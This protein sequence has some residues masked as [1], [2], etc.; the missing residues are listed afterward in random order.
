MAESPDPD[1]NDADF[2]ELDDDEDGGSF[3]DEDNTFS[4]NNFEDNRSVFATPRT[5]PVNSSNP[6][7]TAAQDVQRFQ[8]A[9]PAEKRFL[10]CQITSRGKPVV[11]QFLGKKRLENWRAPT[12]D[13]FE[14]LKANGKLVRGGPVEVPAVGDASGGSLL[15]TIVKGCVGVGLAYGAWKLYNYV[16]DDESNVDTVEV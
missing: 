15:G 12:K 1:D 16:K 10:V 8:T 7:V 6:T 2:V 9:Q 14:F 13:E 4:R 11:A 5:A 3:A